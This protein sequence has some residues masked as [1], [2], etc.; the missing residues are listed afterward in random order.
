[1]WPLQNSNHNFWI[2][3]I[4]SAKI[5]I[6]WL[7]WT[8]KKMCFCRLLGFFLRVPEYRSNWLYARVFSGGRTGLW[9]HS[10]VPNRVVKPGRH[11]RTLSCNPNQFSL[12]KNLKGLNYA[13]SRRTHIMNLTI[14]GMCYLSSFIVLSTKAA[15]DDLQ[16]MRVTYITT[17]VMGPN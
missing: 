3:N 7:L 11:F 4:L 2:V 16:P 14:S 1:M 13:Q 10:W 17:W 12:R 5:E 8:T 6:I 15:H 9:D